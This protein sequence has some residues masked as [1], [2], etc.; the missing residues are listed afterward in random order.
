LVDVAKADE[1]P[2]M[3]DDD[4]PKEDEQVPPTEPSKGPDREQENEANKEKEAT[5]ESAWNSRP[6][7][8]KEWTRDLQLKLTNTGM[9][10]YLTKRGNL[11]LCTFNVNGHPMAKELQQHILGL[12][13]VPDCPIDGFILVDTRT[14]AKQVGHQIS[15]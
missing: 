10:C 7:R 14:H 13:M 8:A 3:S 4:E 2:A 6:R 15:S 9:W 5:G 12:S 1:V 11:H